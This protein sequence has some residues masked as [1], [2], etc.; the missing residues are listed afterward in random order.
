[1]S[2]ALGVDVGGTFTDVVLVDG[3]G[4]IHVAKVVT[5]PS[6]P[7]DGVRHGVEV[8]LER[9][10]LT[11]G[12]IDRFV[13]G[14]TLATNVLLERRGARTALAVTQGFGDIL[15]LARESRAGSA[16]YDL[17]FP[18][19]DPAIERELTFEVRERVTAVGAVHTELDVHDSIRVRDIATGDKWKPLTDGDT[20]L[21]HV[22]VPKAEEAAAAAT[23]AAP[24]AAGSEPE[25]IK[26]GKTDKEEDEKDKKDKK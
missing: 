23:E 11:G 16:R 13:H 18:P 6:D 3:A 20:M 5:T 22:V 1:M 25:V 24:A 2:A 19:P 26:K 14:T 12:D 8:A 7:R 9:A 21:V 10:G 4:T 15:R 17:L